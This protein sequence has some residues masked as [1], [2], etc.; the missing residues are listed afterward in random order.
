MP[1]CVRKVSAPSVSCNVL[2]VNCPDLARSNNSS[3]VSIAACFSSSVPVVPKSFHASWNVFGVGEVVV[4]VSSLDSVVL[5]F[6]TAHSTN[7]SINFS[8]SSIESLR[9]TPSSIA[10]SLIVLKAFSPFS[11]SL[12]VK[13]FKISSLSNS[14]SDWESFCKELSDDN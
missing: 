10:L 2:A 11:C 12:L 8:V 5:F 13:K 7:R 1:I 14:F 4:K 9:I 6:K 3:L